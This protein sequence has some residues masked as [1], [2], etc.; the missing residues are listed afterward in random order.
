MLRSQG[1]FN[2][3]TAGQFT[4]GSPP[5]NNW[6]NQADILTSNDVYA[7]SFHDSSTSNAINGY[8]Y[9]F[10]IPGDATISG[11]A[12]SIEHK[13]SEVNRTT[14]SS[15]FLTKDGNSLVGSNQASGQKWSTND[16]IFSYGKVSD[17]W[18]TTWTPSEINATGFG[19]MASIVYGVG[20][21]STGYIDNM[22]VTVYYDDPPKTGLFS[23]Y[24][25]GD[26]GITVFSQGPRNP[27]NGTAINV[28]S[29]PDRDWISPQNIFNSD[30]VYASSIGPSATSNLLLGDDFGFSIPSGAVIRGLFANV[31]HR[32]DI[33]NRI[34]DSTIKIVKDRVLT[35]G[36]NQ[37]T[38][39]KWNNIDEL[40][41][42]GSVYDMWGLQ[43][44]LTYD[45][46]NSSGFGLGLTC[47]FNAGGTGY[48]DNMNM[49]VFYS[50]PSKGCTLYEYGHIPKNSGMTLFEWGHLSSN[51][52]MTL[53][54]S[55]VGFSSLG[56]P[57]YIGDKGNRIDKGMTLYLKNPGSDSGM[58]LSIWGRSLIGD[59][60]DSIN[61][62]VPRDG[63][64]YLFINGQGQTANIPLFTSGN[65]NINNNIPLYTMGSNF[66]ETSLTSGT[67]D[68]TISDLN[69][70]A[71]AWLK[72]DAIGS[73]DGTP[74][75]TWFDS[76]VNN[77]NFSQSTSA[78]KPLYKINIQNSLPVVRFDGIN[79]T[80]INSTLTRL[81]PY[82]F[83]FAGK[84]TQSDSTTRDWFTSTGFEIVGAN[85][86]TDFMYAGA[87]G[88][89]RNAANAW[90][91]NV[92]LFSGVQSKWYLDGGTPSTAD[93]G[94]GV[95]G[96]NLKI[97][98]GIAPMDLGEFIILDYGLG[99]PEREKVEG[100][101][102]WKW[103]L[104]GNLPGGHT[105]KNAK[106]TVPT[107]PSPIG[108]T[109]VIPNVDAAKI[110]NTSLYSHGF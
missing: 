7:S 105:Y 67:R 19:V 103:G 74:I 48:V 43:G 50:F 68:W 27:R 17:L 95:F 61:G 33:P 6:L 38:S 47:A 20:G 91:V 51:S 85:P 40:V 102:A 106:P 3:G 21:G 42:Y 98:G 62:A 66:L 72:A 15:I 11:I 107:P 49:T 89:S 58:P 76:T 10:N 1:P 5:S 56:V 99:L 75:S 97:D 87:L 8:N 29:P 55:G 79:D 82:E 92:C 54:V 13:S 9:G 65:G 4:L 24:I 36:T 37:A 94:T 32:A 45:Y 64:I 108:V 14:D 23:L 110:L 71:I 18:G 86:T 46:I 25:C 41:S 100:Y 39:S 78:N 60:P 35:G 81:Q 69:V 77:N 80:L 84:P 93:A 73:G 28:G 96:P 2:P 53:Y 104:Q 57:L 101:L 109:L 59:N 63:S 52:G 34:N 12:V 30:N 31:E 44:T 90:H 26:D 88:P 22:R 83:I 70:P 16:E